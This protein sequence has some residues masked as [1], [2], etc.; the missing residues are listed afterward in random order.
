MEAVMEINCSGYSDNMI[1]VLKIFKQIG[2]DVYNPQG[3][4]EYL[5]VGDDDMYNWQCEKMPES[6]LYDIVSEKMALKERIG[7]NLFYDNGI[8]GISLLAE[9]PKQIVLGISVNRRIR[10]GRYTDMAWYLENII[11]KLLDIGVRLLSYEL[12]EYED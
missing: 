7:V 8:E 5:P 4:V 6:K 2:W 11:Y 9:T 12:R 10:K 1:E 3:E